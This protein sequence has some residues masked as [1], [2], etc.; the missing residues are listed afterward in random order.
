[1]Q[2]TYRQEAYKKFVKG[3]TT[4]T[5]FEGTKYVMR[6]KLRDNPA[7]GKYYNWITFDEFRPSSIRATGD[8][9]VTKKESTPV[10]C[11]DTILI[12]YKD[13]RPSNESLATEIKTAIADTLKN[14]SIPEDSIVAVGPD[15]AMIKTTVDQATKAKAMIGVHINSAHGAT[16]TII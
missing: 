15:C 12:Q 8:G 1:M 6:Y 4:W 5:G 14:L 16:I 3:Y 11:P 9:F 2:K 10:D 7:L 13:A